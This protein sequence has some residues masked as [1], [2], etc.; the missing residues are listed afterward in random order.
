MNFDEELV[1]VYF[2]LIRIARR[3]YYH[4]ERA[5]D[6]A[7]DTVVRALEARE[8]FDSQRSLL[9]WC[10]VI[11]HNL[12]HNAEQKLSAVNTQRLGDW[13]EP[14]G[15][16]ADQRAIVGDILNAIDRCKSV[17]VSTLVDAAKGYTMEEIA[18]ARGIPIGT[19]KR[20]IHDGRKMLAKLVNV[21]L[22]SHWEI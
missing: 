10:R 8:R 9:A 5:Q 7:A 3:L 13:D 19:V 16:Y 6:L 22:I 1:A 15:E 4:D 20:R 11:M 14:G 17:T 21:N 18:T 12:W 2:L